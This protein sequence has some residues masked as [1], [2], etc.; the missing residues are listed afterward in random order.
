MTITGPPG[1][2]KTR[3]AQEIGLHLRRDFT[4]GVF[5][6]STYALDTVDQLTAEVGPRLGNSEP[7]LLILD[8]FERLIDQAHPTLL[9]WLEQN[10]ETHLLVTSRQT[11]RIA[12]ERVFFLPPM[13]L[14]EASE[15]FI[16]AAQSV[17][18]DFEPDDPKVLETLVERLDYL[19]LAIQLAAA[20]MATLTPAEVL[21]RVDE[22]F[23][24]LRS[25]TRD[26]A[27]TALHDAIASS[28]R[29]ASATEKQTLREMTIFRS[30]F[31]L[32]AAEGVLSCGKQAA[33][34][35]DALH[36]KSLILVETTPEGLTRY[37]MFHCIESFVREEAGDLDETRKRHARFFSQFANSELSTLN[38]PDGADQVNILQREKANL[39]EALRFARQHDVELAADLVA[40]LDAILRLSGPTAEHLKMLRA[41]CELKGLSAA[42]HADLL[43]RLAEAR[44][45]AADFEEAAE[46]LEQALELI[47]RAS[48]PRAWLLLRQG[49][50]YRYKGD[51]VLAIQYLESARCMGS[52]KLQRLALAYEANCWLDL[53]DRDQARQC[54]DKIQR[55]PRS[56]D[57]RRE[58]E[59]LRRLVYVQFYLGNVQEQRRLGQEALEF[60]RQIGDERL[61]GICLQ[62]LADAD[63]SAGAYSSAV[64]AYTGALSIHQ[65]LGNRAYEAMLLGNLGGALHRLGRLGDARRRYQRSLEYHRVAGTRAYEAVVLFALG[66]LEFEEQNFE[67]A[68]N[69]FS[70]ART[71]AREMKNRSDEA[72]LDLCFAWLDIAAGDLKGASKHAQQART[73]FEDLGPDDEGWVGVSL[74]TYALA[75]AMRG[76]QYTYELER[77]RTLVAERGVDS[78]A[79]LVAVLAAMIDA[80]TLENS[81]KAR[82]RLLAAL[83]EIRTEFTTNGQAVVE[84]ALHARM[85]ESLAM[86]PIGRIQRPPIGEVSETGA[87]LRVGPDCQWYHSD[88]RIDLRRRKS[89]R[90]ILEHLVARHQND[91]GAGTDV[92][93][94][95]DIG[96]PGETAEPEASARRVYWAIRTLRKNGLENFLL[97]NDDG[98]LLDPEIEIARGT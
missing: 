81:G 22:P 94:L 4:G 17:V 26:R 61:E 75:E 2:G 98:Y 60:A 95:F 54:I 89:I 55:I 66:A 69:H 11:L 18:W 58:C 72:G 46:L 70:A 37:A 56:D 25:T 13:N 8:N 82:G 96:W 57:L 71:L 33:D 19:P 12:G 31:Y 68:A 48:E 78:Q 21:E 38:G 84:V 30:G 50:V 43:G 93:R 14:A 87:E 29:L 52:D 97:T 91:R 80:A 47:P 86:R 65:R 62:G 23:E 74:A 6:I 9:D 28:W 45:L 83:N 53:N 24:I 92:Y 64:Q 51:P 20:R 42:R 1:V 32:D 49:D 16:D 7:T 41:G 73:I 67:D 39:F 35:L 5:F 77:S 76:Q 3:S 27:T 88:E 59:V 10:P 90:L 36:G 79:T 85:A 15:M 40:A 63:I 34:A 44:A